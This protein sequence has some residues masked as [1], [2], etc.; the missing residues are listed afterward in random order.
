VPD[1]PDQ[2]AEPVTAEATP[3]A[4]GSAPEPD[5]GPTILQVLGPST[6]GIRRHV[7]ALAAALCE[8][9]WRLV[10]AGPAGVMD[11]IRS[12]DDVVAIPSNLSPG[13]LTTAWRQLRRVLGGVDLVH[14]HG[15]KAGWLAVMGARTRRH[16]PPVVVTVHNI[17]LDETSGRAA[18]I[19]RILE[20]RVFKGA[21]ALVAVSPEVGGY[22]QQHTSRPV[23]VI[24]P[25]G[26][27]PEALRP[28]DEVRDRLGVAEGQPLVVC[29]ARLHPQK[30]L[31]T[32]IEAA[33]LL[34]TGGADVRVAIVGEGPLAADLTD[35]IRARGLDGAVL[36]A[37]PSD[38][39]PDELAAADVVVIPSVW[40]SG[41]LVL[42]EALVLCR[43][44][45]ATPVGLVPEV[46]R[47]GVSGRIVPIGDARALAAAVAGLIADPVAAQRMAEAGREAVDEV[48]GAGALVEA[49]EELY[50][51]LLGPS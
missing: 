11:G 43:P 47:E 16:R 44:V 29:V 50:R 23:R 24:R 26:P 51:D 6:G 40:E 3:P 49:T 27:P 9:G 39:A 10:V 35:Q 25:L 20:R 14:A 18:R 37:G 32:L 33:S 41:P 1:A 4:A 28:R 22:V 2:P 48:W 31:S 7:G 38:N 13:R 42:A 46:I 19:M 12:L 21:D 34:R 30:G 36:L 17:I 5:S 45:V 15:L 8:R